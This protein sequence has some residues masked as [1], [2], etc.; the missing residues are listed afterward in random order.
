MSEL[1]VRELNTMETDSQLYRP[2]TIGNLT[3][4]G[5]IFLAPV[6]GYS[7]RSFRS[8]CVDWGADFT[9]TEMVSSEAYI[10]S[11][12]KTEKLIT[13]AH[14][15][16]RYAGQIPILWQG[17]QCGSSNATTPNVSTLM[18]D[19]LCRRSLKQGRVPH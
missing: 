16:R 6:A 7:D 11:S 10:R 8:I 19:A 9:Y 5:N 12:A 17:R 15:E 13:R 4:P 1:D 3:L 14:N 18:P 2:V